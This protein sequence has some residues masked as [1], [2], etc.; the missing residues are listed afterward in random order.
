MQG[1]STILTGILALTSLIQVASDVQAGASVVDAILPFARGGVVPHAASGRVMGYSYSGDN[2]GNVRLDAGELILNRA[3]QG[4]IASQ[5]EGT[6][7]GNYG[8][9]PYVDGEKIFLG[10]NNYLRRSGKGEIV[11]AR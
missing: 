2:I 5:L 4:N 8:G 7:R 10:L 11:T 3:Q 1:I 9:T 6:A